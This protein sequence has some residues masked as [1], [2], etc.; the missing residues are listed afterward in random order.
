ME[1]LQ[2][3]YHS[4]DPLQAIE[5]IMEDMLLEDRLENTDITRGVIILRRVRIIVIINKIN[6][7]WAN[8]AKCFYCV[9]L[10]ELVKVD[11]SRKLIGQVF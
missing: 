11:Y 10:E 8:I 5:R 6:K 9:L 2:F 1:D 4:L 7:H 3:S